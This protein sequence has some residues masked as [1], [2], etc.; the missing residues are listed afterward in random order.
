MHEL[1][2]ENVYSVFVLGSLRFY[3]A[4]YFGAFLD[5]SEIIGFGKLNPGFFYMH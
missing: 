2:M 3:S 4:G 5:K 1:N